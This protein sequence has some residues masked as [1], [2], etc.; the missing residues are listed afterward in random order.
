MIMASGVGDMKFD[1]DS[2][3]EAFD[4]LYGEPIAGREEKSVG[5]N[6]KRMVLQQ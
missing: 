1:S 2:W 4:F 3:K 5:S 6:R